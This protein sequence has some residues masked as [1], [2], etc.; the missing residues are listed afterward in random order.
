[1][2]RSLAISLIVL[3]PAFQMHAGAEPCS[4]ADSRSPTIGVTLRL[5]LAESEDGSICQES[6]E[7]HQYLNE[8]AELTLSHWKRE[9][10]FEEPPVAAL[11]FVVGPNG[12]LLQLSV[13]E[14]SS[15]EVGQ[16]ATNALRSAIRS[17]RSKP[18]CLANR[19]M[20]VSFLIPWNLPP[21]H[22]V[23]TQEDAP[24]PAVT[25]FDTE[26]LPRWWEFWKR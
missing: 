23:P 20:R 3:V 9:I 19:Q 26:P 12:E 16:C 4:A 22:R 10:K 24:P 25:V 17:L 18:S 6:A 8:L 13:F 1:M 7:A 11:R 21:V 14:V 5:G 2:S 15:P